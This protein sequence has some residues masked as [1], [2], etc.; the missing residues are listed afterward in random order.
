MRYEHFFEE[1]ANDMF[2]DVEKYGSKV[3]DSKTVLYRGM[4]NANQN[5]TVEMKVRK[6]RV[7]TDTP[8]VLHYLM[9][10]YFFKKFGVKA[11]SQTVFVSQS[12]NFAKRYG[13]A[14]GVI[15]KGPAKYIYSLSIPD[16]YGAMDKRYESYTKKDDIEKITGVDY[17]TYN[18][19]LEI[20]ENDKPSIVDICINLHHRY[21]RDIPSNIMDVLKRIV[22]DLLELFEYIITDDITDIEETDN[23]I[24]VF[25]DEYYAIGRDS[26]ESYKLEAKYGYII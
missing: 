17:E 5:K 14:V 22:F 19:M 10:G 3:I 8:E 25:C 4:K 18:S 21:G 23:E 6:D 2:N 20:H 15:P 7:P 12:I 13:A 1:H 9:D 11:R 24:M 16:L 26:P